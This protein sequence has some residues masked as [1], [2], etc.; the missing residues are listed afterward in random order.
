[1]DLTDLLEYSGVPRSRGEDILFRMRVPW[2][3]SFREFQV[4]VQT[5]C[6]QD[7]SPLLSDS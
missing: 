5:R 4:S 1:M 2:Y 6:I 7:S 3:L